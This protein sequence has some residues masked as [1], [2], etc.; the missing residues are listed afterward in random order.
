VD[1]FAR[2]AS[3]TGAAAAISSGAGDQE[4]DLAVE[5]VERREHHRLTGLGPDAL[6]LGDQPAD[7]HPRAIG[8]SLQLC[9]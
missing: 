5:V 7:R 4:L 6:D 1:G 8:L 9:E 2:T 3:R